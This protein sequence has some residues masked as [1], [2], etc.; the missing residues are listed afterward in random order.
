[1]TT[2]LAGLVDEEERLE[3]GARG[4]AAL[5]LLLATLAIAVTATM[6]AARGYEEVPAVRPELFGW[7]PVYSAAIAYCIIEVAYLFTL[8]R[9]KAAQ[10]LAAL[11]AAGLGADILVGSALVYLTGGPD[12]PFLPLLFAWIIAAGTVLSG[13]MAVAAASLAVV[14]LSSGLL[15]RHFC[16]YPAAPTRPDSIS[17]FWRAAAF[18]LAQSGA[19]FIVAFL[20]G[21]LSRHLVAAQLVADQVLASMQEGLLVL[22]R[23]GRISFANAEARRLLG[24][25]LP[26]GA[27]VSDSLGGPRLAAVKQMLNSREQFGPVTAELPGEDGD[28]SVPVV[29]AVSGTP[30]LSPGRAFRGLIVVVSDRSAERQLEAARRLA[31]QRRAVSELAMSIAHEIR[32]PLGAVRSAVQEIGREPEISAGGRE[33]VDVVLSES[34]R[35]DRIVGDFLTFARPR[36][37]QKEPVRLRNLVAEAQE[38]VARSVPDDRRVT[39]VNNVPEDISLVADPE[40]LRQALLNLGLNAAAAI[41]DSGRVSVGARE[42][43]LAEFTAGVSPE[44]RPAVPGGNPDQAGLIV[45]VRDDGSGMD[46]DTLHKAVEPFFTT[47]PGG[48]GLGLSIVE[49]VAAAHGGAVNLTSRPGEGTTVHIWLPART[50]DGDE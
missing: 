28:S 21:A 46:E 20:A 39:V 10:R 45:E 42:A 40:Q 25:D 5:R 17:D 12:S 4:V 31:E 47:R 33:L 44:R 34:D 1:M 7:H 29:L 6:E 16:L 11:V 26:A 23:D 3:G 35:L 13:R 15:L 14:C 27:P 30:V 43:T 50:E 48:T 9:A 37:P 36:P 18:H 24:V 41:T 19:L 32:N 8:R 2:P 38:L 49:R 22:D